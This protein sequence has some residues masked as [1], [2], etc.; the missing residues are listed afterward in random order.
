MVIV[1]NEKFNT[2]SQEIYDRIIGS[3]NF[4]SVRCTCGHSGCLTKH[5]Y[6]CRRVRFRSFTVILRILR[7]KCSLCGRTHAVLLSCI[8]PYSQIPLEDQIKIAQDFES[9]SDTMSILETN[10]LID[11]REVYYLVRKYCRFWRQRL[12]S[13]KISSFK[14]IVRDCFEFFQ[15]QFMQIHRGR[16]ILFCQ[17]T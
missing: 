12:L 7:V 14:N 5:A 15:M 1:F 3:I 4:C 2:I 6:Y 11:P 10:Y 8:V 16:Q 13:E 9:G 17:P